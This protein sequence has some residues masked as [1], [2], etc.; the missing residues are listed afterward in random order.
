MS[1]DMKIILEG[2]RDF[3]KDKPKEK[4]EPR[5]SNFHHAF[6]WQMGT[7]KEAEP[8]FFIKKPNSDIKRQLV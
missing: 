7:K 5:K 1:R 3:F 8:A 6:G 2:W 4:T